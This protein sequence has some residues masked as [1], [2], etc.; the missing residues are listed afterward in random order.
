[1]VNNVFYEI[2]YH[3]FLLLA[4]QLGIFTLFYIDI[5]IYITNLH[6]FH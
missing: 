4:Q 3:V 5:N 6:D 1:M 2:N